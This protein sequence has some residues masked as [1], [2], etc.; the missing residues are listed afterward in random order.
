MTTVQGNCR[1]EDLGNPIR[2]GSYLATDAKG[3][4]VY[5][6]KGIRACPLFFL[7]S[8]LDQDLNVFFLVVI[9]FGSERRGAEGA[10]ILVLITARQDQEKA[11][12]MGT[13]FRQRG[14]KSSLASNWL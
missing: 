5:R 4:Q 1:Q 9:H 11:F 13:A 12:R 2:Y 6:H 3:N 10:D 14:Q 7:R 8:T